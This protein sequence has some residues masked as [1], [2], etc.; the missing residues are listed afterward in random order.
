MQK[1]SPMKRYVERGSEGS[2]AQE[3]LSLW[4]WGA[5]PSL[6]VGPAPTWKLVKSPLCFTEPNLQFPPP[7]P[8]HR[9]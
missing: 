2:L 8:F 1:N 7:P 5:P 4:N 9:G 6:Q 3:G